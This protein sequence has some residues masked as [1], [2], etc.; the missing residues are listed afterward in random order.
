VVEFTVK[1][2]RFKTPAVYNIGRGIPVTV[3]E[4]FKEFQVHDPQ[5]KQAVHKPERFGEI[6]NFY[7]NIDCALKTEWSPEVTLKIGIKKTISFFKK[8]S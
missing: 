3:N 5:H 8:L 2:V 6:G 7:S 4:I 1:S